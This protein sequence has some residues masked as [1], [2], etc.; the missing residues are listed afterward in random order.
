MSR[1]VSAIAVLS[2]FSLFFGVAPAFAGVVPEYIGTCTC[3][4]SGPGVVPE[5]VD[6]VTWVF[7]PECMANDHMIKVPD[8][9]ACAAYGRNVCLSNLRALTGLPTLPICYWNGQ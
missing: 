7:G 6:S 5:I 3:M 9:P 8:A 4:K 2:L 1:V